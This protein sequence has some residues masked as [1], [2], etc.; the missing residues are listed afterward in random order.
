MRQAE[1]PP[2]EL[3]RLVS[4]SSYGI[5]DTESELVFD[6]LAEL[7]ANICGAP[8]A[9]ISLVDQSRQWFKAHI[10]VTATETARS[11]SF[12]AHAILQPG[13]FIVP[14]TLLDE[15]FA[16]NDLVTGPPHIRFYAG[17]PLFNEEG[18]GLGT[19][20]VI[21]HVPRE[22]T[23]Q[24][25]RSLSVLRTHVL[26][27]LELR[28]KTT[29]LTEKNRELEVVNY[30]VSH[31]LRAPLRTMTG[32]CQILLE[33]H[34]ASLDD[35]AQHLVQR[36][37]NAAHRMDQITTDLIDL[38]RLSGRVLKVRNV[39]LTE[40]ADD[41]MLELGKIEP[42]R[43]AE[44]NIHPGL[45][46]L[47]DPGL[48]RVVVE[49]LLGN[50]WK[51]TAKCPQTRIEFGRKLVNGKQEFFVSDNGIGFEM[52]Y[53][54][55]L[56]QPFQR[57]QSGSDYPGTGIGLATVKRIIQRHGG[58]VRAESGVNQGTRIYFTLPG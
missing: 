24:Q 28:R 25:L 42:A 12:C 6:E 2:N 50:A 1:L 18:H 20:C 9:L 30:T 11:V 31:D 26:K 7:A 49:N 8:I 56:F 55:K 43:H 52:A 15:R 48:L 39:D 51:F 37:L 4:L 10:G 38:S 53:A 16:D 29:A 46:A 44:V 23:A 36:V 54:G 5:L 40:L 22:L 13:L 14:D 57:L 47:G 33:D 45:A 21:D 3:Q 27:L 58:A 41:V 35:E 19:L 32:F 17:A 34:V